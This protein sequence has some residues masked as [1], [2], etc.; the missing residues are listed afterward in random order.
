M[1]AKPL[2]IPDAFQGTAENSWD[3]WSYHF[4]NVAEVNGW[5]AE[6]KLKWLKVRLTGRAQIAFQHLPEDDRDDFDKATK[7][8]KERFEP[9]SKKHRYQAELQSRKK[10]KGENWADFAEDLRAISDKAYPDLQTEA[11]E[12]L[13][14][15]QFL[16]QLDDQQVAFAVK[17]RAPSSLDAAVSATLEMESY[18]T[19]K[20]TV[21]SV[22]VPPSEQEPPSVGAV[23]NTTHVPNDKLVSMLEKLVD[24]LDK[25]ETSRSGDERRRVE[26]NRP[27]QQ[28][29]NAGRQ[30]LTCWNCGKLGHLSR[31]CRSP[32]NQQEN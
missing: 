10:K 32:R 6:D 8:L 17:Q 5:S 22:E 19:P 14:L 27:P 15:N 29:R 11:R 3:Q 23:S 18:M 2:I 13:A 31:Q 24:R 20:V 4:G 7:A 9:A 16:S 12:R 25:L 26:Q 21:S 28:R 30:S 1:A